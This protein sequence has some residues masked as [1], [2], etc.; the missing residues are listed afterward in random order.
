MLFAGTV[1]LIAMALMRETYP[2][3]RSVEMADAVG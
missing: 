3:K 2:A 1:G